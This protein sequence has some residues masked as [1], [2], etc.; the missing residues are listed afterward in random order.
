M[1]KEIIHLPLSLRLSVLTFLSPFHVFP[2][3]RLRETSSK[4]DCVKSFLRA[5]AP[6]RLC[7]ESFLCAFA[8]NLFLVSLCL[9]VFVLRFFY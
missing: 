2:P 1:I 8:L 4:E 3:L 6:L 7:V 9:C 5:F